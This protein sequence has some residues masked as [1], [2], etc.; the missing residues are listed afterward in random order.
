MVLYYE[1]IMLLITLPVF[2]SNLQTL[3]HSEA[4]SARGVTLSFR[5][6]LKLL[7]DCH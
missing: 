4:F 3:V 2:Q 6:K 7:F 5:N 1:I